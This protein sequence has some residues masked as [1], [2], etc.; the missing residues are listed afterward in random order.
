[1]THDPIGDGESAIT[2][3]T[4]LELC[5]DREQALVLAYLEDLVIASAARKVG[6]SA[7][8]A[9]QT[10]KRAR[11]AEAV[12]WA[13]EQRAADAS[14]TASRVLEEVR[15]LALTDVIGALYDDEGRPISPR[16]LPE[17]VR[18]CIASIEVEELY[19]GTGQDRVAIG[20]V[21]KIKVWDKLKA[22][23][24]LGKHLDLFRDRVEHS[25]SK[26]LEDLIAE[27][28]EIRARE[29]AAGW[30][31]DAQYEVVSESPGLPDDVPDPDAMI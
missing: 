21:R 16:S 2:V 22:I 19:E 4:P 26:S 6:M 31:Q 3:G 29:S 18:R 20:R 23:D 1:M 12:R 15:T 9:S 24:L 8:A 11:V 14:V 30:A 25:L 10:L 7:G 27:S 28:Y 5:T 17:A 13:I